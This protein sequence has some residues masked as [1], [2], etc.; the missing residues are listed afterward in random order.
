M[1]DIARI[2]EN[3]DIVYYTKPA[4]ITITKN[5]KKLSTTMDILKGTANV[6]KICD[7]DDGY[8]VIIEREFAIQDIPLNESPVAVFAVHTKDATTVVVNGQTV[9]HTHSA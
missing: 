4:K 7:F 6:V 3:G 2:L 1:S 9:T 8:Q 5:R